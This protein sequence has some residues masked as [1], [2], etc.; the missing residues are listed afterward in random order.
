MIN[1]LQP[2]QEFHI[3]HAHY[4]NEFLKEY[5]SS[6]FKYYY[7]RYILNNLHKHFFDGDKPRVASSLSRGTPLLM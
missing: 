7:F 5:E 2:T 1:M 4:C 3:Q 6:I